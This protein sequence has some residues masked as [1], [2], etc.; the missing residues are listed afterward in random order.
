M[1]QKAVLGI[2]NI[3]ACEILHQTGIHPER[4][5]ASVTK[6]EW[7]AIF[8]NA[9]II[10]RKAIEKRGSSISDWRDLYGSQGENQNELKAY[11]RAG[12]KCFQCGGTIRRIK[13]GGRSTFYCPGCQK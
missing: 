11:G 9:G 6:K 5:A 2:G 1:D 13:Q 7:K 12:Q 3:Y 10:L 8:R 4:I